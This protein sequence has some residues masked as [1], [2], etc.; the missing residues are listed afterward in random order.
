MIQRI[1]TIFL[2][3]G[4][5]FMLAVLFFPMVTSKTLRQGSGFF[6]DGVYTAREQPVVLGL[7]FLSGI[8]A[9]SGIFLYKKRSLQMKMAIFSADAGFLA[10]VLALMFLWQ[11]EEARKILSELRPGLGSVMPVLGFVSLLLAFWNIRKD[12]KLVRSMDRLR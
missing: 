5:I 12:E 3:L 10:I 1:Q 4:G 9:L 8:L 6:L 11:D 2:L 7:F